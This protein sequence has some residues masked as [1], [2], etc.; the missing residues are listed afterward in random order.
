M[1][2]SGYGGEKCGGRSEPELG[3]TGITERSSL[4]VV[5]FGFVFVQR[6]EQ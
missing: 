2:E 5:N 1:T 4:G 3:P 6:L